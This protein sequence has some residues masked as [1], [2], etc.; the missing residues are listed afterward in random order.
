MN[1]HP[2]LTWIYERRWPIGIQMIMA[3]VISANGVLLYF[4]TRDDA[5]VPLE[6]WYERAVNWDETQAIREG[7]RELGWSVAWQV[8]SGPEYGQ[9]MPRPVDLVVSD[10]H[11]DPISG[12]SGRVRAER[13]MSSELDNQAELTELPQTPGAYRCLLRFATDGVWQLQVTLHQDQL[14]WIGTHR[15]ELPSAG[16]AL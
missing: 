10:A 3:L 14:T 8:P 4:A 7:S 12:L 13:P 9:G 16:G 11:G 15:I 5:P 6:G 1:S 2:L